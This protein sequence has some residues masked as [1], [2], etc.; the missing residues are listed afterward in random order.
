MSRCML[1]VAEF[2]PVRWIKHA[3]N[4]AP[5]SVPGFASPGFACGRSVF[6]P[7]RTDRI[8]WQ[9]TLS[10]QL[11]KR[12]LSLQSNQAGSPTSRNLY[13]TRNA[14]GELLRLL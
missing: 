7:P 4:E 10:T 2:S 8:F 11:K 3:D 6:T 9:R 1:V 13:S 14:K 12:P 5:V